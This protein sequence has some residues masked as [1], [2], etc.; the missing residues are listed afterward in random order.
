MASLLGQLV[1]RQRA[2]VRIVPASANSSRYAPGTPRPLCSIVGVDNRSR[3]TSC[4]TVCVESAVEHDE[5]GCVTEQQSAI[6]GRA[7]RFPEHAIW[8]SIYIKYRVWCAFIG[9]PADEN[10]G[11]EPIRAASTAR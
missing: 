9:R 1:A 2:G 6:V 3:D 11:P 5:R 10:T 8:H 4:L 7:V